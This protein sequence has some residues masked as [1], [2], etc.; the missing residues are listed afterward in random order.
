M[1]TILGEMASNLLAMGSVFPKPLRKSL[2]V[3]PLSVVP[4]FDQ[5]SLAPSCSFHTVEPSNLPMANWY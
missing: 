1:A 5:I 2:S 3:V 4:D